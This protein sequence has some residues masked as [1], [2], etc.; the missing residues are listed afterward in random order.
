VPIAIRKNSLFSQESLNMKSAL[1]RWIRGCARPVLAALAILAVLGLAA[2][3]ASAAIA[4]TYTA[5][6]DGST[7]TGA[8]TNSLATGST[9]LVIG[10]FGYSIAAT[11]NDPAGGTTSNPNNSSLANVTLAVNNNT[12]LTDTLT[13]S[14]TG[15]GFTISPG[16]VLQDLANFTV[17][18]GSTVHSTPPDTTTASSSILTPGAMPIP[19]T[20]GT[21]LVGTPIP[22]SPA[23]LATTYAFTN[24]GASGVL[25]FTNPGTFGERQLLV[26]TLGPSD[27]ANFTFNTAVVELQGVPEPSSLAIAGI[28]AL[29]LIGFGLRRRKA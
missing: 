8:G 9:L 6:A 4:L 27:N 17:S 7:Q 24:G 10:N 25:A 5:M 15:L 23:N 29:G 12:A 3:S 13:I 26:I 22:T 16:A 21:T 14:L 2:P 18:G 1:S 28:G 11:T 20:I 19:T